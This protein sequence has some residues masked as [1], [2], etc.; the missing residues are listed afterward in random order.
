M[1]SHGPP[2]IKAVAI[3]LGYCFSYSSN[4]VGKHCDQKQLVKEQIYFSLHL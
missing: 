3:L 1:G 4:D 2:Q